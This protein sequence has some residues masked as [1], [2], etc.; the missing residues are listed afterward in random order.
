MYALYCGQ[1]QMQ[2]YSH[3]IFVS[4]AMAEN[5]RLNRTEGVIKAFSQIMSA[6]R[7]EVMCSVTT[8]K[9]T[10]LFNG[11]CYP[12][13][14]VDECHLTEMM[15]IEFLEPVAILYVSLPVHGYQ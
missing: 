14:L 10:G 5:G 13:E 4:D 3:S 15:D 11:V 9:V 6:H 7:G 12:V 2:K 8:A 1:I